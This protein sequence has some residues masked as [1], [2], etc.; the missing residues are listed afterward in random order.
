MAAKVNPW[1][2]N[3]PNTN[4]GTAPDYAEAVTSRYA[5]PT[6]GSRSDDSPYND[7]FGWAPHMRKVPG[8]TPDPYRLGQAPLVQHYPT[9]GDAPEGYYST[10][11]A[12]KKSRHSAEFQDADG[13]DE[14]KYGFGLPDPAAG[15]HRWADNPRSRPPAEPRVTSKL[16]PS[17]YLFTRPFGTGTPKIGAKLF[18]GLHFSMADHSRNYEILGMRPATSRRNT[19]RIEPTPWDNEVVDM[20]VESDAPQMTIAALDVP[21]GSRSW[22]LT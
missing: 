18:N 7:E 3:D 10:V 9:P 4:Y 20:P 22:R 21:Y 14:T 1:A 6:P 17:R 15:S 8:N 2:N 12:D 11:D 16:S 5:V 19:Y 13:W